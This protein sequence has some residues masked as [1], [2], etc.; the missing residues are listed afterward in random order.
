M[1]NYWA[2]SS[3]VRLI[4]FPVK[5]KFRVSR[6]KLMHRHRINIISKLI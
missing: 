4:H 5:Q 3:S 6:A 1:H 2:A